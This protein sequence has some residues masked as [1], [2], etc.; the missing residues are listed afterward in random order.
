MH[1]ASE[2]RTHL[3]EMT[4][5]ARTGARLHASYWPAKLR[6]LAKT[7][8]EVFARTAQWLSFGEYLHRKVLGRSVCSLS[9]ASGTG[10]LVTHERAWDTDFGGAAWHKS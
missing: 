8:P 5:H 2:L 4:I 10:L 7:R 1:A 6:W 9:M 3:D